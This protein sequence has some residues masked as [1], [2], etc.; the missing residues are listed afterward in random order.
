[1]AGKDIY[2]EKPLTLCIQE[3]RALVNAARK[4]RRVLQVGSQQ[5]SMAMNRVAC[6]LVRSG[7]LGKVLEVRAM[8]YPGPKESPVGLFPEE[9]APAGLDWD[10]W[11]NQAAW[12]PYNKSWANGW[13]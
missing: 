8:N 10:M 9:P 11:L 7:G 2:A 3:G 6:E 1:Q 12:R 4:H 5:R 13:M